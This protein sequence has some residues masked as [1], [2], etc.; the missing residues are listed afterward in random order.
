MATKTTCTVGIPS[1]KKIEKLNDLLSLIGKPCIHNV[2]R[3]G[4]VQ[5]V[6]CIVT[7][8]FPS[9]I[10]ALDTGESDVISVSSDFNDSLDSPWRFVLAIMH[11]PLLQGCFLGFD[12]GE[13]VL[14]DSCCV[15]AHAQHCDMT[16]PTNHHFF[17]CLLDKVVI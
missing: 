4:S 3:V 2:L 15:P 1:P 13:L 17:C 16:S 7:G 12:S 14:I 10:E 5:V 9:S 6:A 8:K 11:G